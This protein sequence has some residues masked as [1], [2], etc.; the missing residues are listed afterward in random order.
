MKKFITTQFK[1]NFINS[2]SFD[3]T[4]I[5]NEEIEILK[6][7]I[8]NI[9]NISKEIED[10]FI[11]PMFIYFEKPTLIIYH[12][13]DSDGHAVKILGELFFENVTLLPCNVKADEQFDY[14]AENYDSFYNIIIADLSFT[15]EIAEKIDK[16]NIYNKIILF[17][18]HESALFLNKYKWAYVKP[19]SEEQYIL[20]CGAMLFLLYILSKESLDEDIEYAIS[21]FIFAIASYDTYLFRSENKLLVNVLEMINGH[22]A[23]DI[24]TLYK[25]SNKDKLDEEFIANLK[26]YQIIN[27][28]QKMKLI[29]M[30]SILW[31]DI[32]RAYHNISIISVKSDEENYNI[33][34]FF[35][36]NNASDIGNFIL[37]NHK[38]IKFFAMVDLNSKVLSYRSRKEYDVLEIAIGSNG[39]DYGG[40]HQQACGA[41]IIEDYNNIDYKLICEKYLGLKGKMYTTN[42]IKDIMEFNPESKVY[43]KLK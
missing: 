18:H 5:N 26:D 27:E 40:G 11:S 31:K 25:S 38:D 1:S 13:A 21:K 35:G 32:Y 10:K 42:K 6:T 20:S 23:D 30:N 17:D 9:D 3:I 2:E 39:P 34:L 28:K 12:N 22:L 19:H 15:E 4:S 43:D 7:I 41:T 8:N 24:N 16:L 29:T 37:K 36:N 33:A 14:I